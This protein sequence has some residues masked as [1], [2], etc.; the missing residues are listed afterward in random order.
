MTDHANDASCPLPD[1]AEIEDARSILDQLLESSRLY[2]K[3]KDYKELLDHVVKLRPFAPF[4]AMLL[5]IQKPGLS[6]AATATDWQRRFGRKPKE[7]ARPLLI[8]WPFG[9]VALVFDQ[10]DTEG[11]PLPEDAFAFPV[12]GDL[13]KSVLDE[14][15]GRLEGACIHVV[16][17]DAG[18]RRAGYIRL[19]EPAKSDR[20]YSHYVLL[21]NR[22][23]APA[24]RFVT[25][26]HELG[27]LFLGHLGLDAKLKIPDRRGLA[28][29]QQELEAESVAYIL[30]GRHGV[31][32]KSE[33]YLAAFITE[34]TTIGHLDIY[35]VMRAA[36]R[37]ESLLGLAL[38]DKRQ[39]SNRRFHADLLVEGSK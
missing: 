23:H 24:V 31:K 35:Q 33:T 21:M 38:S 6:Y 28:H 9:P 12:L 26:V 27:H 2:T 8:L 16:D 25:L 39:A 22:N 29:A 5:Q 30:C 34:E 10:M 1:P 15:L 17:C 11:D 3:G 14:F 36:G 37:A 20:E 32:P 13:P 4:N 19:A 18:D 7:G